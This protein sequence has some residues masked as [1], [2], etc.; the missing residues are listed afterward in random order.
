MIVVTSS[1]QPLKEKT[2]SICGVEIGWGDLSAFF[3]CLF[4]L[5]HVPYAEGCPTKLCPDVDPAV[6]F[7]WPL[8]IWL[9]LEAFHKRAGKVHL[10]SMGKG[11]LDDGADFGVKW[12]RSGLSA[13]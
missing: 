8:T 13:G 6:V 3:I 5:A 2:H 7:E 1:A 12:G 9:P 10:A 11:Q 4:Y